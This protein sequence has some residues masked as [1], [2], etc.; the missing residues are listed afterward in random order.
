MAMLVAFAIHNAE[1]WLWITQH[2][3]QQL[4]FKL[5]ARLYASEPLGYA[6]IFLTLMAAIPCVAIGFGASGIWMKLGFILAGG[7]G[8]NTLMHISRAMITWQ[9]NPGL[10]SAGVLLCTVILA[11]ASHW[12][13]LQLTTGLKLVLLLSG[14]LLT[15]PVIALALL[16]GNVFSS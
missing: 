16:V 3:I 11:V 13:L 12:P 8:L 9:Y 2:P 10:Y 14:G 15:I 5:P 1:E 6:M 7:L 4:P